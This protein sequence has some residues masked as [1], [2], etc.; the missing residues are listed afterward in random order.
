MSQLLGYKN[1]LCLRCEQ[2]YLHLKLAAP[3]NGAASV[4]DG[5]TDA[6]L[7]SARVVAGGRA[8]PVS[9]EIGTG[10]NFKYIVTIRVKHDSLS[11]SGLQILQDV[12]YHVSVGRSRILREVVALIRCVG[13]IWY[14]AFLQEFELSPDYSVVEALV[15]RRSGIITLKNIG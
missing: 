9:T 2:R 15:K 4:Q 11:P 12:Y 10:V 13:N 5:V 3:N 6:R 1:V 8:M 14:V 7:G